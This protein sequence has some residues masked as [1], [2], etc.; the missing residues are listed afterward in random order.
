VA[1]AGIDLPWHSWQTSAS[2]GIPGASK[3]ADVAAKVLAMTAVDLFTNPELLAAAKAEFAKQT[4]GRP[5]QS[6]IPEGQKPPLP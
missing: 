1:T 3:A 2:H 5:Y 4:T 6:A